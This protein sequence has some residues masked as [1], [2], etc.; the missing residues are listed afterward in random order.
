MRQHV[1]RLAM[2]LI[3]CFSFTPASF[4]QTKK[5]ALDG[6]R[7]LPEV[8]RKAQPSPTPA[9]RPRSSKTKEA[10]EEARE[11]TREETR[12]ETRGPARG[13]KKNKTPPK[14]KSQRSGQTP[15]NP[16]IPTALPLMQAKKRVVIDF[17]APESPEPTVVVSPFASPYPPI[18]LRSAIDDQNKAETAFKKTLSRSTPAEPAP[19]AIPFPRSESPQT[20]RASALAQDLL[21]LN[22]KHPHPPTE[23]DQPEIGKTKV[24]P[25]IVDPAIVGQPEIGRP[26]K[27]EASTAARGPSQPTATPVSVH[28]ENPERPPMPLASNPSESTV[29]SSTGI[30]ILWIRGG[31]LMTRYEDLAPELENG[32]TS[33]GVG[34]SRAIGGFELRLALDI[35]HGLDQAVTVQNTRTL[36]LTGEVLRSWPLRYAEPYVSAGLG[37]ANFNVRSE[38]ASSDGLI[39]LLEHASGSAVA[40]IPA[41]GLRFSVTRRIRLEI[42]LQ[43]MGLIGPDAA[44]KLSAPAAMASLGFGL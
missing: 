15:S 2:V 12:D 1:A 21:D 26:S 42:Q 16:K 40:L 36:I 7:P 3:A 19:T 22:E 4:G 39:H 25:A 13:K 33:F 10:R 35:Q 31:T 27:S 24:D 41:A 34:M 14:K 30:R 17:S 5:V 8:E 28:E 23:T 20:P 37:A 6:V 43:Y 38:R 44:G 11:E 32:A 18:P 9:A 29:S